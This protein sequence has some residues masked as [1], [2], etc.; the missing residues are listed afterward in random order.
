[1]EEESSETGTEQLTFNGSC[2]P[3]DGVKVTTKSHTSTEDKKT[4]TLRNM[5]E[6]N[7]RGADLKWSLFV[8]ACKSYRYDSC[9]KPFPPQFIINGLKDIEYL[10]RKNYV[11]FIIHKSSI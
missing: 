2:R 1:M 8:A 10:V 11:M 3:V 5:L 4:I 6:E 9:L 7:R